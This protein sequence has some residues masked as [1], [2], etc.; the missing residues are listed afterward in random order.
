MRKFLILSGPLYLLFLTSVTLL[1][2]LHTPA[3]NAQPL[4]HICLDASNYTSNTTYEANLKLLFPALSSN[5]S[6]NHGFYNTTIGQDQNRVYGL[7]LCRGDTG[8]NACRDCINTAGDAIVGLCPNN[9]SAIIWYDN[10]LLRF[11]NRSFF[12]STENAPRFYMWNTQN[13]SQSDASRFNKIAADLM[14]KLASKAAYEP[15][16]RMFATGEVN[17][18]SFIS[19]INGLVQCVPYLSSL[20]CYG[21]L[22]SCISEVPR[23][24]DGLRGCR[25]VGPVCNIRFETYLFYGASVI[26]AAAPT[27]LVSPSP[28]PPS[29][30]AS[31][32]D[33]NTR[34]SGKDFCLFTSADFILL[35]KV[36]FGAAVKLQA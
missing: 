9:R 35:I 6:L 22:E 36:R 10:C 13:L 25:V 8:S 11:S 29:N 18:A 30:N 7:V 20:D 24:C 2:T 15:W 17:F 33:G 26:A 21:C 16:N 1:L 19:R 34:G 14:N 12:G 4:Y 3:A 27:P 5:A 23:H 28:P 32:T 31:S